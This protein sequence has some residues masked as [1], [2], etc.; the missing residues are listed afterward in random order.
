MPEYWLAT[1]LNGYLNIDSGNRGTLTDTE[2]LQLAVNDCAVRKDC[3]TVTFINHKTATETIILKGNVRIQGAKFSGVI[4][5]N[6]HASKAILYADLKDTSKDLF[7]FEYPNAQAS[8]QAIED[9]LIVPISEG[10]AVIDMG[11]A[12][13]S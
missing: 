9:L 6:Y 11:N 10:R 1:P 2:L 12:Y 7:R 3:H 5:G 4:W 8:G 13:R